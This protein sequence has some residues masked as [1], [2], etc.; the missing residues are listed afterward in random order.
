[1]TRY[2]AIAV[3]GRGGLYDWEILRI[4]SYPYNLHTDGGE[5]VGLTEE[6]RF[7]QETLSVTSQ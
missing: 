5:V 2:E 6:R 7:L 3:S 4:P 1:M